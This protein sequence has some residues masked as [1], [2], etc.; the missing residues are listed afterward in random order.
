MDFKQQVK[1]YEK[2]CDRR[3]LV[4]LKN[5]QQNMHRYE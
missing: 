4:D 3:D 2:D 1:E 5:K